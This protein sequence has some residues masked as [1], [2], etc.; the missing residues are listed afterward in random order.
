MLCKE[1]LRTLLEPYGQEHLI[2]YWDELDAAGKECL[3]SD[4]VILMMVLLHLLL[5]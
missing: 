1:E 5:G 2:K 4:L 3:R